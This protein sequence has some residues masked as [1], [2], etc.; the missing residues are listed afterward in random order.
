[1]STPLYLTR[2][3]IRNFRKIVALTINFTA[4]NG[5]PSEYHVLAGPN[6]CGKTTVLEAIERALHTSP[7]ESD[8]N[9]R[10]HPRRLTEI[11]PDTEL[12]SYW[13]DSERD[14]TFPITLRGNAE[15]R[16]VDWTENPDAFA[17]LTK[18][19]AHPFL[20]FQ[21]DRTPQKF[22]P[23]QDNT[24]GKADYFD[25]NNHLFQFKLRLKQQMGRRVP[26]YRGP[27]PKDQLWLEKLNSFWKLFRDDGTELVMTLTEL[28]DL[29]LNDWDLFLY[30]G[31]KRIC[32][33]DHLSSGE[34]E[35]LSMVAPIITEDFQGLVLID[36]PELHLHPEWQLRLLPALRELLPKS[37]FV[38]ASHSDI[39]WDQAYSWERTLLVPD[40]DP[41]L[42]VSPEPRDD[43][44]NSGEVA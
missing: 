3:E 10:I 30:K 38:V 6:G 29:D 25:G 14:V 43:E 11:A 9:S 31:E 20:Y 12:V 13:Y 33:A 27:E 40:G 44:A 42:P 34:L 39:I 19:G 28:D 5:R 17:R 37:Q 8:P 1:M 21:S 2:I 36:E 35:V 23:V 4:P 26:G 32:P 18:H 24:T 16:Y 22:G 15:P 41:R 7:D